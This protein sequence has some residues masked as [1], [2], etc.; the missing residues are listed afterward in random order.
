MQ[1]IE[2]LVHEYPW[3]AVA[4]AFLVGMGLALERRT[5]RAIMLSA[6]QIGRAVAVEYAKRYAR[7]LTTEQS[8]EHYSRA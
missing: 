1:M 5:R 8:F 6:I 3:R 4:G 2:S 7:A